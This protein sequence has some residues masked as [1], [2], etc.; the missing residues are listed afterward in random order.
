MENIGIFVKFA[1]KYNFLNC[2]EIQVAFNKMNK[3]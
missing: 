1:P 3:K 2:L